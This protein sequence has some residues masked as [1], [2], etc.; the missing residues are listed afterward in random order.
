M[1]QHLRE[2]EAKKK[3]QRVPLG[4]K[5]II[6]IKK[7]EVEIVIV[8]EEEVSWSIGFTLKN[9]YY[10]SHLNILTARWA[11]NA[12]KSLQ[13]YLHIVCSTCC[14]SAV[15]LH[16]GVVCT[17]RA[18]YTQSAEHARWHILC[19]V[20]QQNLLESQISDNIKIQQ[21]SFTE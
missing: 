10:S 12:R 16:L 6:L 11:K 18:K 2:F 14:S 17:Q 15:C 9:R 8:P 5:I 1:N 20:L 19:L 21:T 3:K 7:L 4:K 13:P